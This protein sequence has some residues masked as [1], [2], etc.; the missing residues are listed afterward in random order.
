MSIGRDT[1][2]TPAHIAILFGS[3]LTSLLCAYLIVRTTFGADATAKETSVRIW[4]FRGPMGAFIGVW[5]TFLMLEMFPF[6]NWWHSAFGLDVKIL[7]PPHSVGI[8]GIFFMGFGGL[9][10]LASRMNLSLGETNKQLNWLLM[11]LGALLL[12]DLV[13]LGFQYIGDQTVM[14]SAIF[15]MAVGLVGPLV[16]V[17]VNRASG[18]RWAATKVASLY[19]ALWLAAEWILPL[20]P[21]HARLGPVFT[22]ITHMVPMGFPVL[23]APGGVVLDYLCNHFS[24]KGKWLQALVAGSGFLLTMVAVQWPFAIFLVSPYARNWV[25]GANY[26]RYSI[27]PSEYHYRWEFV[28]YESSQAQLW[29]GMFIVWLATIFST[30][31]GLFWGEWLRRMRR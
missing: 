23:L 26:F 16:L 3:V 12:S 22:P 9:V 11:Y 30:R 15:Y 18:Q 21:A 28:S 10:L 19:M 20:F 5:G 14:H 8:S 27:P 24:H 4:G 31:V 1:F 29:I 7:T 2:W 17:G 13:I 25:F 6:D